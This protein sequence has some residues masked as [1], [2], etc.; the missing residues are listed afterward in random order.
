MSDCIEWTGALT[1]DG[2]PRRLYRGNANQRW[3]RVV[4]AEANGLDVDDLIGKVVR[5]TCDNP[6]CIN[7]EHL[8]IG[9]IRDNMMDRDRRDRHGRAKLTLAQAKVLVAELDSGLYSAEQLA[10]L[11][12]VSRS[13]VY[14]QRVRVRRIESFVE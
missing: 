2:Y 12:D 3:H 10:S 7:P 11:Y 14:Y 5:H 6:L 8:R 9:C 1:P 4:C 13:T